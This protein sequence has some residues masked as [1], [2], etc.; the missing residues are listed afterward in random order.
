MVDGVAL[1]LDSRHDK[2]KLLLR[3][4]EMLSSLTHTPSGVILNRM[5]H[6]KRNSYFA[7]AIPS[8][9]APEKKVSAVTYAGISNGNGNGTG[10]LSGY[11]QREEL[12][13][14]LNSPFPPMNV[15]D[16]HVITNVPPVPMPSP[17][18]VNG[19]SMYQ[20]PPQNGAN[21]YPNPQAPR[22]LLQGTDMSKQRS[23]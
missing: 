13:A 8:G 1:I 10:G 6:R 17:A 21:V 23:G 16:N 3:M 15:V 4:K 12:V 11:D 18:P 20:Q 22:S 7:S 19:M 5:P 9:S 2:L 14:T